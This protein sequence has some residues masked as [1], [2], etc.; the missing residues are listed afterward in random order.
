GVRHTIVGV[1]PDGFEFPVSRVALWRPWRAEPNGARFAALGRLK[2]GVTMGQ[3]QAFAT[4]TRSAPG[5]PFAD[6]RVMP[7]VIVVPAAATALGLLRGGV[8][9]LLAVAIANA[10]NIIQAEMIRRETEI[11]V[12]A[13]LGASWLR[14]VRPFAAESLLLSAM[15]AIVALAATSWTLTAIVR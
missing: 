10:A 7:F 12:R 8:V 6:I 13:S 9:L 15:A 5:S 3:A 2:R 1:M 14:L 11:A 4:A